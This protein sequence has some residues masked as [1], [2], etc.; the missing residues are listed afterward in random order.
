VSG[1]SGTGTAPAVT[2]SRSDNRSGVPAGVP[3]DA[4]P[5]QSS[6][7]SSSGDQQGEQQADQQIDMG[8]MKG[9]NEFAVWSGG[10]YAISGGVRSADNWNVGLRYGRVLTDEHG[11]GW[12]RGRF[13]YTVD[14][15]PIFWVFQPGGTAYGAGFDPLGLKWNFSPHRRIQPYAGIT[16]GVVF[17]NRPTPPGISR[18]NFI[19]S[20][21][22]GMHF[23]RGKHNWS[24]EFRYL[25]ISD[26][27]LTAINP[28]I[29]T[30]QF[31]VSLG[32]FTQLQ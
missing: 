6:A 22:V 28:G 10:G 14:V 17:T 15:I 30:L 3:A 13:E 19:P 25:H 9:S 18:V 5:G 31:R 16:G 1:N 2:N 29:N 20:A 7:S 11:P 32:L 27:G 8:A 26:A 12:L 23:L 21:A 24:V 4:P